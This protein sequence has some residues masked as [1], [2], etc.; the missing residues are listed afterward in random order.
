MHREDYI[1]PIKNPKIRKFVLVPIAFVLAGWVAVHA[2]T[3]V[4]KA[5]PLTSIQLSCGDTFRELPLAS[6]E[7][8][9]FIPPGDCWSEWLV[10]PREANNF[11]TEPSNTIRVF[12]SFGDGTTDPEEG[13]EDSP[14]IRITETRF[15]T[16][17]RIK[18]SHKEPVAV[19]IV[20]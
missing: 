3:T 15:I 17:A 1:T 11:R 2:Y 14:L 10:R 5:E 8:T 18:N 9:I 7:T 19:K 4:T 13:V 12:R 20:Y 16:G 6:G